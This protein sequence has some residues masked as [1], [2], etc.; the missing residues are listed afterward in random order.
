MATISGPWQDPSL[1]LDARVAAVVADLGED[2]RAAIALGEFAA[3][4]DRGLPV[5]NYVD[6]GT[7]LRDTAGATAF[8]AGIALAATFD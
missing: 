8:P 4:T 2:E 7:G 6:A 1:D 5:P 3:L